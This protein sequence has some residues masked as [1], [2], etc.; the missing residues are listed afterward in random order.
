MPF[1]SL[2]T[3]VLIG[4]LVFQIADYF[5]EKRQQQL[6]N[7][8]A[9]QVVTGRTEMKI[10]GVD[11]WNDSFT[12][13]IL[14]EGDMIRTGAGSRTILSLLNGS[15]IRLGSDTEIELT[16]LK[17]RDGQDEAEFS[18]KRGDIW[19]KRTEK[20]EV[21]TSFVVTT[22]HLKVS[23]LGTIFSVTNGFTTSA[24]EDVRV[25]NGAVQVV[26]RVENEEADGA[27]PTLRDA[28]TLTVQLGQQ[29]SIGQNELREL[30]ERRTVQL[31]G[32]FADHFR[33]SEWF[34][35][36]RAQDESGDSAITVADAV[37]TDNGS[38]LLDSSTPSLDP[39]IEEVSEVTLPIEEEVTPVFI[40]PEILTPLPADRT[41]TNSTVIVT[42]SVE[43]STRKIEATTYVAGKPESYI[44]QKYVSGST[45]WS[46][47]A[48]QS[49]GN[50]VPGVN[51]YTFVAIDAAGERS[52]PT[53][54]VINYDKPS[55]SADLS[56]PLVLTVNGQSNSTARLET[57]SSSVEITGSIGQGIVKVLVND[58]PLTRYVPDSKSWSY[59]ARTEYGNLK[60]GE[61][62]YTVY[63]LSSDGKKTPVT[64]FTIIRKQPTGPAEKPT[65]QPTEPTA[66]VGDPATTGASA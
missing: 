32:L 64:T 28:E 23:S 31:V 61:N 10:W 7:K 22:D 20:E 2:I 41:T 44:L 40:A 55:L 53:E 17:T 36:N 4:V 37:G 34:K 3:L 25:M 8:A 51:R 1:L 45:R 50:M 48:S 12:G 27:I 52:E 18:L 15:I 21:Q 60:I 6:E 9:V 47:V 49:L 30:Q 38:T 19:L 16:S 13:A 58:F 63:G 26:V 14:H 46:Y 65:Q 43:S 35:W 33:E 54:L 5:I 59:Y 62:T 56:A 24:R 42:G 57:E 39:S 29:V 11:D 66:P